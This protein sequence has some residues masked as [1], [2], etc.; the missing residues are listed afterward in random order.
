MLHAN[1]GSAVTPHRVTDDSA[2]LA[3]RNRTVMRINVCDQVVRDE[4][5]E[6]TGG[7]RTRI[8][9]AV[10]QRLRIGQTTIIS[11]APCAKAPSIVS[12]TWISWVHCS[13]PLE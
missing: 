13:A 8:H 5:L 9:G 4:Q 3:L 11:F 7:H 12:G 10:V 2:T 1:A 6:I